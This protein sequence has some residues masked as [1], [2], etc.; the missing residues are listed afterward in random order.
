MKPE[1]DRCY[2]CRVVGAMRPVRIVRV[3]DQRAWVGINL[4]SGE[5]V[6][7]TGGRVKRE[8]L[9]G[10]ML[11]AADKIRTSDAR[12]A[13]YTAEGERLIDIGRVRV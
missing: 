2:L 7:V 13:R 8:I 3:I 4:Y 11:A 10:E 6:R 5:M 9:S 12:R 1:I